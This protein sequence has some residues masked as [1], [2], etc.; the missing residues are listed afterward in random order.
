MDEHNIGKEDLRACKYIRTP[1]RVLK[2]KD[3]DNQSD[4]F[5]FESTD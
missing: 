5:Q 3:K 2:D 4:E 1:K